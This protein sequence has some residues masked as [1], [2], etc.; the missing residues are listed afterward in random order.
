MRKNLKRISHILVSLALIGTL[1]SCGSESSLESS[2]KAGEIEQPYGS[3]ELTDVKNKI[4]NQTSIGNLEQEVV[5]ILL[6]GDW[7]SS[8]IRFIMNSAIEKA[9]DILGTPE[10]GGVRTAYLWLIAEQFLHDITDSYC[11]LEDGCKGSK[12]EVFLET[13]WDVGGVKDSYDGPAM[14]ISEFEYSQ[15]QLALDGDTL[16]DLIDLTVEIVAFGN[17][18]IL[19]E[20][21]SVRIWSQ[22]EMETFI[23]I[24]RKRVDDRQFNTYVT[25]VEHGLT[26]DCNERKLAKDTTAD[27]CYES[28]RRVVHAASGKF[29]TVPNPVYSTP[30]NQ[31]LTKPSTGDTVPAAVA[32]Y[33]S[34]VWCEL[35]DYSDDY[36]NWWSFESDYLLSSDYSH[37]P[38]ELSFQQGN[39]T[40]SLTDEWIEPFNAVIDM[41]SDIILLPSWHNEKQVTASY[42]RGSLYFATSGDAGT[43]TPI[44]V[45]KQGLR[46]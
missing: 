21:D 6:E 39:I 19:G 15:A 3:E 8:E 26:Q 31:G 2:T 5:S 9:A 42:G 36:R 17:E 12:G 16:G 22:D 20:E 41:E 45:S 18:V 43:C 37:V 46:G 1:S 24:V 28:I 38:Y 23:T 32:E 30:P 44:S 14:E 34:G 25:A 33:L 27:G 7:Q 4:L 40:L 13:V 29:I 11:H 10:A 35:D